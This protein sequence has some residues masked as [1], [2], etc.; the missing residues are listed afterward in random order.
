M[1]ANDTLE[2]NWFASSF[3]G[4]FLA[5]TA[6]RWTRAIAG[7]A[8]IAGGV[9]LGG[10]AGYA[11]AVVGLVPLLAGIFDKCVFSRLFG[12]PFDGAQIRAMG[13]G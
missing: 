3:L 12:G 10:I 6:G 13:R 9:W 4:Q 5:S 1:S 11:I 8:L 2:A 7:A